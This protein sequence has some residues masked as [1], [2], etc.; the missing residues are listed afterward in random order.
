MRFFSGT[1]QQFNAM[2]SL[3]MDAIDQP[4]GYADEPWP[5]DITS[6]ALAPHHYEPEAYAAMIAGA[7]DMGVVEISE[8]EYR[9]LQPQANQDL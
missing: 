5:T 3:A 4:N 2:R 8:A 7:L 9:A 1:T 6:L